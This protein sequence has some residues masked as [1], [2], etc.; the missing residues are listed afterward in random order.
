LDILLGCYI[1]LDVYCLALNI[2]W[3]AFYYSWMKFIHGCYGEHKHKKMLG[4]FGL[5]AGFTRILLETLLA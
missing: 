2:I 1:W 3:K 5:D 4:A